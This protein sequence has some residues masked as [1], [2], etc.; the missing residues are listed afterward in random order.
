MMN[1]TIKSFALLALIAFTPLFAAATQ[2]GRVLKCI[3][4]DCQDG[5]GEAN[6]SLNDNFVGSIYYKGSF[7]NGLMDGEGVANYNHTYIIVGEFRKNEP[8]GKCS[9][10]KVKTV[11]GVEVPDSSAEVIFG[12]WDEDYVMKGIVV[13]EDGTT[14]VRT[15]G[16]KYLDTKK[17][18]D[19]WT[20]EQVEGFIATRQGKFEAPA[21]PI[22]KPKTLATDKIN[23]ARDQWSECYTLNCLT[24]RQ[25]Y[26]DV[27]STA[28]YH[29]MPFGGHVTVQVV[30]ADNT[31]AFE[32]AAGTYW[33]PRTEGKYTF[34]LKFYQDKILGDWAEH[35]SY[36]S[37][38]QLQI[39]LKSLKKL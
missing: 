22:E 28:K 26:I 27:E 8:S 9:Q 31:V 17:V 5:I 6:I 21:K 16:H 10:W 20:N 1:H 24:D 32:A 36:V 7:K 2:P 30:A 33:T 15:N 13:W 18:K 19:K 14:K 23:L 34:Q 39:W 37:G 4:G 25:Y 11:N 12:K 29:A 3:S 38:V 35:S